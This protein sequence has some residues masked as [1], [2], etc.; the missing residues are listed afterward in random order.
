MTELEARQYLSELQKL[1]KTYEKLGNCRID[2]NIEEVYRGQK[3]AWVKIK[4][5]S[6]KVD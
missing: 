1:N 4:D 3:L 2:M 5:L 6:L